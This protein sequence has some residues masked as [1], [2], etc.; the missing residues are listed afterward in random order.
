VISY[1]LAFL[2]GLVNASGNV[3][4]RKAARDE[5]S[6]VQFRLRLF[7][8]LAHKPVWLAAVG[9]MIVS[10]ALAAAALGTG[11]L[12]SVQ[13]V[14]IL[15]LPMTII[16]SSW[17]LRTRLGRREWVAIAA[18]TAGVI[19]LLALL[20]PRPGSP[21][22]VSPALWIM[23]SAANI[24]AIAVL[25][26]AARAHPRPVT[27]GSLL[28]IAAGLAY[29]LTAAYTKAMAD[30]F[31]SGGVAGVLSSWELYATASAGVTS[32]WLLENAYQAGPLTASQPGITLVD[33][34][35]STLWGVV[36]FG[37]QIS[38]GVPL[39][40]TPIPLLAVAAGVLLLSRSPILHGTQTGP[41]EA[42]PGQ[43]APDEGQFDHA[44]SGQAG[45]DQS[46]FDESKAG[47]RPRGTRRAGGN[48]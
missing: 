35:I 18:M 39:A 41:A 45:R 7:T 24:G 14:V 20:H 16:G 38:R 8:D 1:V 34:V 23:G 26:L 44:V 33:P 10:F 5:P 13:L 4:N 48:P 31:S 12:A 21:R 15:E 2:A 25:Y 27:R 30:Q 28:G 11:E 3:L 22:P 40:L 32:A 17:L 47:Q 29:G 36:V 9:M 6:Q 46:V 42:V 43:A 19:G 37:E